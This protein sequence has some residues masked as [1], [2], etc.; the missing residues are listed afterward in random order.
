MNKLTI[1]VK[2]NGPTILMVSGVVNAAASVVL[3]CLATKRLPE[4]IKPFSKK[5]V[6]IH[7]DMEKKPEKE[8]ELKKEL[9]KTYV[10]AG[11]KVALMYL[12]CVASFGLSTA[13]IIGSHNIMKGRNAALAAALTT[14]KGSYDA[15]REKVRSKIGD[16]DESELYESVVKEE[17][18]NKLGKS[19]DKAEDNVIVPNLYNVFWGPDCIGSYCPGYPKINIKHLENLEALFQQRLESKGYV[20]LCE[21][22]EQLGI[23]DEWLS[24]SELRGSHI[25][26]WRY[27]KDNPTG[28]NYISFG[29]HKTDEQGHKV[30]SDRAVEFMNG[31]E[32]TILLTFNV[33]GDIITGDHDQPLTIAE[34]VKAK[35][36]GGR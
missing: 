24:K 1:W 12:P 3:G 20:M 10:K 26:G 32:D 29:I 15:Y 2:R 23:R 30:L 35:N 25:V 6:K 7:K 21:V 18:E 11:S 17:T 4:T 16:K 33:D 34:A 19:I 9:A 27:D 14:V 13:S 36:K 8:K 28:N 22:Y 5:I 31:L